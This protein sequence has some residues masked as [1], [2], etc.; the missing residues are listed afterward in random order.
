MTDELF[1]VAVRKPGMDP[2]MLGP[3]TSDNAEAWAC[4][5]QNQKIGT[6][7]PAGT[8]I[9]V[10]PH[11]DTCTH[12]DIYETL[13]ADPVFIAEAIA[14][15]PADIDTADRFPDLWSRLHMVYGFAEASRLWSEACAIGDYAVEE[16]AQ[17]EEAARALKTLSNSA[18]DALDNIIHALKTTQDLTAGD[19]DTPLSALGHADLLAAL[20]TA[21]R[22]LRSVI[23]IVTLG[24]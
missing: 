3:T 20:E 24:S 6:A 2:V 12:P 14:A 10:V 8:R 11:A 23:R 9:D 19:R 13:P 5:L 21:A 15:A 7:S 4:D 22:S 1:D 17:A 18:S 16:E